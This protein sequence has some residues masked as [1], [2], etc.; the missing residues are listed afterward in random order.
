MTYDESGHTIFDVCEQ[1][2]K[3]VGMR[4]GRGRRS[5]SAKAETN[6]PFELLHEWWPLQQQSVEKKH[7]TLEDEGS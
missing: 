5:V 2:A 1:G 4:E 3:E 6:Q 7:F